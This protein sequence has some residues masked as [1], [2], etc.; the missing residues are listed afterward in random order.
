MVSYLIPTCKGSEILYVASNS[1]AV[2]T[3]SLSDESVDVSVFLFGSSTD[4][5]SKSTEKLPKVAPIVTSINVLVP[6][7]ARSAF[8]IGRIIV[9]T[10]AL[11]SALEAGNLL[12]AKKIV[13]DQ[14]TPLYDEHRKHVDDLVTRSDKQYKQLEA[15]VA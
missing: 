10:C 2:P 8:K 14:L 5:V 3:S 15:E 1:D 4:A 13:A 11:V 9:P 6:R 12:E 7:E